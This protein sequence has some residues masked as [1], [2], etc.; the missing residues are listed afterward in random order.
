[1]VGELAVEIVRRATLEEETG[2]L[3][4]FLEDEDIAFLRFAAQPQALLP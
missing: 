2:A 1:M 3:V 4:L